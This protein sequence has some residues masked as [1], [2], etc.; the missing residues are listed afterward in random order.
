MSN[1]MALA[2]RSLCKGY[3]KQDT[4]VEVL[5]DFD[6]EVERGEMLAVVGPSGVGKSTLLHVLGLLDRPDSGTIEINGK[7]VSD[8]PLEERAVVR[9]TS[10]G[11][12]FQHHYLLNEF[13]ARDNVALPMRIAGRGRRPARERATELLERVGLERRSAHFPDQLSG[14]EQQRVAFARALAMKPK[15]LLADEP[16]G[17]LDSAN[18]E[19]VFSLVQEL[20]LKEELTSIIVTHNARIAQRCDRVLELFSVERPGHHV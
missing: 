12:V 8:L 16:T 4:R 10:I 13:D 11:F 5:A 1:Q 6:L 19:H 18:A 3:G 2:A 7:T 14:G 15:L 20:H 17:K 9:N